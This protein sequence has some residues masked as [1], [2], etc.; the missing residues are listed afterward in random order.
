MKDETLT[1]DELEA[2]SAQPGPPRIAAREIRAL[3]LQVENQ[4]AIIRALAARCKPAGE[5]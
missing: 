5:A 3:R 4:T 2:L 1:E